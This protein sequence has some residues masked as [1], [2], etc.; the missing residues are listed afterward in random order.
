MNVE[1]SAFYFDIRKDV[2]YCDP[3]SSLKRKS[4]RSV[5]D[6]LFHCLVTWWAPIMVFTAEEVWISR[7]DHP[8]SSVHVMPFAK[9]L[10]EWKNDEL[11]KKWET[12]R[13]VRSVVTGALEIER[14]N[15]R[16]GSSLEA[17]PV[18]YIENEDA[19]V[20]A[21]K[22]IDFAEICIVSDI[23]VETG[24]A[25]YGS[26]HPLEIARIAVAFH[27]AEGQKCARSWKISKDI[28]SDKDFPDITPRDAEAVREWMHRFGKT[29]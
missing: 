4:C 2:L 20:V 10:S 19:A 27:R 15:K 12:I 9:P 3:W 8:E 17:A 21:V 16:I 18:V 5:I 11:A 25:P 6:Q 1:L 22:S 7:F 14:A 24:P 28:G 23:K 29:I 13:K 26:F